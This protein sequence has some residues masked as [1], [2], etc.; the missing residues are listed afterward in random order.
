[1]IPRPP[2]SRRETTLFPYTTLFRSVFSLCYAAATWRK[3]D[4][5]DR[6]VRLRRLRSEEHTSEIQ[7]QS[8][9]SY[10]VFCLKN[11]KEIEKEVK[12]VPEAIRKAEKKKYPTATIKEVMEV[13]FF[14]GKEEQP[15]HHEGLHSFP[16]RRSSD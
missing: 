1:M 13:Y 8:H 5:K 12:E 4:G 15:I 3:S 7:S 10:A 16:T 6:R 2:S 9:N 14:T 11:I